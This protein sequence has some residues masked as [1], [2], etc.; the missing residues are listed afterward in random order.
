MKKFLLL[1]AA[2]VLLSS[3]LAFA[4]D[5]STHGY[6]RLRLETSRDLDLQKH[7]NIAQG[8]T[9]GGDDRFGT[10]F[11]GQHRLRLDPS[12]KLNDN[13]SFHAQ[14]DIL[15]D[16]VFGR[17]DTLSLQVFN[18][19]VGTIALPGANG[20]FGVTGGAAGDVVTGGGGSFNMRRLYVDLLTPVGKFRLGRQPSH[21]GLGIFQNDGNDWDSLFGDT[22][23]RFL[24]IGKYDFK[25]ASSLAFVTLVDFAFQNTGNPAIDLLEW[26]PAGTANGGRTTP[27]VTGTNRD[28]YQF[29]EALFYQRPHLEVGTYAGFRFRNGTGQPIPNGAVYSNGQLG[30][31]AIDGNT[32]T[33]FLD[34]YFKWDKDPIKVQLEYVYVGG[35]LGTGVCVNAIQTPNGVAN[36]IQTPVCLNGANGQSGYNDLSVSMGALEVEGV[37]G[38]NEWKFISGFAEGDSNPLSSKITQFGF[39]PDYH[40][41]L[42][43]FQDPLGTSPPIQVNGQTYLGQQPV[44]SNFVNNAVY[45]GITYKHKFDISQLVPEAQWIKLGGHVFTAWAPSRVLDINLGQ[46]SNTATLPYI[47]NSSRWYGVE[48][49]L[50]VEA[51]FFDHIFWNLTGAWL[52]PGSAYDVKNDNLANSQFQA[53]NPI[54]YS[55]AVQ[56]FAFRSTLFFQF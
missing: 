5:F 55:K 19:L 1:A 36:P 48:T 20:A 22:F 42:L 30:P 46:I 35:R 12:L 14:V 27:R 31:G 39:R 8:N 18:P 56:A 25:D 17:N 10:L 32:R 49:D 15:D 54:L 50:I 13:I 11:Y 4:V 7:R 29:T 47:F 44:T 16:V 9:V 38:F 43:M 45:A 53:I 26:N 34:T 37:H 33:F 6:Y 51:K 41:A 21:W 28:T 23:D 52:L 24:Y 2:I 3:H 40:V